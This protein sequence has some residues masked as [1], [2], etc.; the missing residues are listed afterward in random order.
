MIRRIATQKD[1]NEA[2]CSTPGCKCDSS[3]V[4]MGCLNHPRAPMHVQYAKATG[5]LTIWCAE[6]GAE[7]HD[8]LVAPRMDG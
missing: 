6:C 8:I 1:L 7:T 4:Y 5:L 3:V 2:K